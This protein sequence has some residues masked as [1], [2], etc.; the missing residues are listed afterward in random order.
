MMKIIT[1]S[2]FIILAVFNAVSAITF[3]SE[4]DCTKDVQQP[5]VH[6]RARIPVWHWDHRLQRCVLS[7]FGG[8]AA[9]NNN[10]YSQEDC[11]VIAGPIC[12]GHRKYKPYYYFLLY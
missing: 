12:G 6:C 5:F 10:F 1:F 9:T 8:C 11:F 2:L 7:L 4:D 3:F